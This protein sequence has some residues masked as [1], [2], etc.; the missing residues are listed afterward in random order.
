MEMEVSN[1]ASNTETMTRQNPQ[2]RSILGIV[3]DSI[4]SLIRW[5]APSLDPQDTSPSASPIAPEVRP[6]FA[7]RGNQRS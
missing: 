4:L 5:S 3:R 6:T 7:Q 1:A 2:R